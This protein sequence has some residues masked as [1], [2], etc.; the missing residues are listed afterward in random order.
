VVPLVELVKK[1]VEVVELE[2]TEH[3]F[4]VEQKLL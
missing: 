1:V 3:L 4:Q 2:V